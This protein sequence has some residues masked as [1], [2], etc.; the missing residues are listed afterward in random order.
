MIERRHL[1]TFLAVVDHGSMSKAAAELYMSQPSVSQTIQGLERQIGVNLFVRAGGKLVLT[2]SGRAFVPS[3]R[4]VV[5]DF[6]AA[7][8]S[9]TGIPGF[10]FSRLAVVIPAILIRYPGLEIIS[11]FSSEC[12][13]TAVY[14]DDQVS[15]TSVCDAIVSG[16]SEIGLT[17][18]V[19]DPELHSVML[20]KHDLKLVCPPGSPDP[21]GPIG[22]EEIAAMPLIAGPPLGSHTRT[23]LDRVFARRG[24]TIRPHIQT[25]HRGI[26]GDLIMGGL[27]VSFLISPE[28]EEL[29]LR[30]AVVRDTDP[31]FS[32]PFYIVYGN[33]R[34]SQAAQIFVDVAVELAKKYQDNEE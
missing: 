22:P 2:E 12:P 29:R 28:A 32:R 5:Y 23:M 31:A 14:V 4:Q 21:G 18:T 17:T 6:Q 9:V 11:K 1:E 20:G 8:N 30:G 3:A 24:L 13:H 26:I 33:Q 15:I 27:G 10:E 34:L 25:A 19:D 7:V 16:R